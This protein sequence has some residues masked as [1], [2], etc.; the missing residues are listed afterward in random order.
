MIRTI[1]GLFKFMICDSD[2][3]NRNRENIKTILF[4]M[5]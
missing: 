1:L 3:I 4:F 5:E 2:E